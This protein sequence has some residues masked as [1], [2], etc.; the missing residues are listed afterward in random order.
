MTTGQPTFGELVRQRR[1]ARDLSQERVAREIRCTLRTFQNIE[2]GNVQSP[3]RGVLARLMKL[4][5]LTPEDVAA[6]ARKDGRS[7]A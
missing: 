3:N 5:D 7:E 6:G 2:N 4:L 1:E